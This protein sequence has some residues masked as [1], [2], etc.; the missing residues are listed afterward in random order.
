MSALYFGFELI[1][2][3]AEAFII[4]YAISCLFDSKFSGKKN[5][6]YKIISLIAIGSLTT[7]FNF[8][9]TSYRDI[10][11]IAIIGTYII[12]CFLLYK[13]NIFFVSSYL[14]SL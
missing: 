10:L 6:F 7:L 9:E 8:I 11:D 13:G 5:L 4:L 12:V 1:A 14:C 2:T 3:F